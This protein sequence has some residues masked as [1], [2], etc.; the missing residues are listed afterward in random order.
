MTIARPAR[1][2]PSNNEI[3]RLMLQYFYDRNK[4]ATS[5][6]GKKGSAVRISDVKAELKNQHGLTR[7]E[8]QSNL[9][10]LQSQGWVEE[11]RIQKQIQARGGTVIPSITNYYQIT[12]AGIDKIEGPGEF[13]MSKFHGIKIEATGQNII[14]L[15]DG[16]QIDARFSDL[17]QTLV[18]FRTAITNSTAPEDQK[19]SLVADIDTV[20]SQLAKPAPN[21]RIIAAAWDSLQVAAAI[22][23]CIGLVQKVGHLVVPFLLH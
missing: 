12:A 23:G 15:G 14:T 7:Q 6:M 17:G 18:D 1:A 3:R 8:V 11:R 5:S 10:Y 21:R 20:Q 2:V 4:N 13:T 22:D 9:T 16:N 19:M